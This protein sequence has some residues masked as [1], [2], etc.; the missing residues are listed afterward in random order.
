MNEFDK[1]SL[2]Y[3][4]KKALQ[5]INTMDEKL[6][7][8][9][10]QLKESLNRLEEIESADGGEA[11]EYLRIAKNKIDNLFGTDLKQHTKEK[12]IEVIILLDKVFNHFNQ[13][14]QQAKELANY[15]EMVFCIR[16]LLGYVPEDIRDVATFTWKEL[17]EIFIGQFYEGRKNND[18]L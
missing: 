4:E 10:T 17:N 2:N 7:H 5:N 3:L 12:L 1:N 16:E 13:I 18:E 6:Y 11:M 9:V 15:K 8:S 14:Q